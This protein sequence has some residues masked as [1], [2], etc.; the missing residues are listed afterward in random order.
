M[1]AFVQIIEYQTSR[2]DE[3]RKL[4]EE[5]RAAR[6]ASGD[7]SPPAR[8][9]ATEDR[10]R[11]GTYCT[12]VEFESYEAAMENSQR[13]DTSDFAARMAELCDGPPTFR[14]LDVIQ[15]VDQTVDQTSS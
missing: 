1:A 2:P 4:S 12:I 11:K 15:T 3:V 5:F 14:N 10:D 8:V 7:G 9:V 6:T 13:E